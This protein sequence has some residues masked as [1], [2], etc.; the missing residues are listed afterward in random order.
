MQKRR[1]KIGYLCDTQSQQELQQLEQQQAVQHAGAIAT[2]GSCDRS[3]ETA[4]FSTLV[5]TNSS[6][7]RVMITVEKT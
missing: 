1:Q 2:L 5:K 4:G 7:Y 6:S 3:I